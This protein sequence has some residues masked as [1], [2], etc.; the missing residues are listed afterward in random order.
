MSQRLASIALIALTAISVSAC[1]TTS[2]PPAAAASGDAELERLMTAMMARRSPLADDDLASRIEA[3]RAHPLG[4]FENPVRASGPEGQREYLRRLRCTNG[5]IPQFERIGN[6]GRGVF[7]SVVDGY[8]VDCGEAGPGEAE[9]F[10]DMYHNGYRET[11][12]VPG[13]A[14]NNG[15]RGA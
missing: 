1:A 6:F 14:I 2:E 11:D 7:G 5:R 4:S 10:M 15:G 3:A 8:S 9:V 13:F 12:P